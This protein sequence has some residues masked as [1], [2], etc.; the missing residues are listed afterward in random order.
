MLWHI[1]MPRSLLADLR[2]EIFNFVTD[3]SNPTWE[4]ERKTISMEISKLKS[5][6][7]PLFSCYQEVL[8]VRTH[9]VAASWGAEETLIVDFYLLKED[10]VIQMPAH[11]IHSNTSLWGA[12]ADEFDARRFLKPNARTKSGGTASQTLKSGSF[13]AFG[14]GATLCQGRRFAT[15]EMLSVVTILRPIFSL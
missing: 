13:R 5:H 12:D 3:I 10:S 7:P 4:G 2:N 6:R 11:V 9:H 15:T 1:Y 14:G 8:H